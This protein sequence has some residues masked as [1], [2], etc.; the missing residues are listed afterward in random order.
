MDAARLGALASPMQHMRLVHDPRSPRAFILAS[1]AP[2]S[3]IDMNVRY[4]PI[5]SLHKTHR[6]VTAPTN[7]K[8]NCRRL[9]E[10]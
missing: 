5:C 9:R 4:A 6:N 3:G 1:P 10:P 2:W 7:E 8:P